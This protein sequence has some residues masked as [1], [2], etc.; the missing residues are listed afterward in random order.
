[1]K[2]LLADDSIAMRSVYRKVLDRIGQTAGTI[3]EAKDGRE[4][5]AAFQNPDEPVDIIVYDWDLPGMDGLALMGQLKQAG[6]AGKVSVLFSVNRQQRALIPQAARLGACESIDRPFTEEI[7]EKKFR[8]MRPLSPQ[9]GSSK[10]LR[11]VSSMP[12]TDSGQPFLARIP[13]AMVDDLLKLADEREHFTGAVLLRAGQICDSLHIVMRGQ[14]DLT[15][16]GRSIRLIREGDLF[17]EFSFM[18]SEP[19]GYTATAKGPVHTAS[20]SKARI[21][22]LL[23]KHPSLHNHISS[24]TARHKEVM[25]AR[26]TTIVQS[27]FKGTFDTMP[28]ANVLQVLSI[29]R[30]TGVLG[31]RDED[32]SGGIY[33]D[34]GEAVHAW[35]G[36]S[37]GE[38]AFYSLSAWTQA[39]FAFNSIRREEK[40]TLTKATITL[41]M[42]A[43][44]RIEEKAS[45]A[46]PSQDAGL[47]S[48]FG[49]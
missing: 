42:E 9:G 45:S 47:E 37:E 36:D 32:L 11:A 31:I 39:K 1:M 15:S 48:L 4:V 28:F 12:E 23:R 6:L 13:E 27:D 3:L 22:D 40:R 35:T 44:R 43:M 17:G 29:G 21:S 14:V 20:L 5:L 41:L 19:S 38:E 7:F 10:S 33:L 24:L 16:A 49:Q 2:V 34:N 26:A 18:M 30:K 46:P 8:A 25:T